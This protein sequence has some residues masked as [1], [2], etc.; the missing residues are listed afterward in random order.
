M[1][2][3]FFS[4]AIFRLAVSETLEESGLF[5][6]LQLSNDMTYQGKF[7]LGKFLS[8]SQNFLTFPQ[9][10]VLSLFEKFLVRIQKFVI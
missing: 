6:V 1:K 3:L 10:K 2:S 8:P 7:C 4:K 9:Q 5:V